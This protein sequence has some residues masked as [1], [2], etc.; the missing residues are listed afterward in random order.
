MI[1]SNTR[2][3]ILFEA[4]NSLIYSIYLSKPLQTRVSREKHSF[5]GGNEQQ[6]QSAAMHLWDSLAS[7]FQQGNS[8]RHWG[9]HQEGSQGIC[10]S[11]L[12]VINVEKVV[13]YLHS[14]K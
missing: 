12:P 4:F 14:S 6:C 2:S 13:I 11:H 1:A 3:F 7:R 10:G 9:H 5:P 8:Q